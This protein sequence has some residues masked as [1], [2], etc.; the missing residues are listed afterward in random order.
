MPVYAYKALN[1]GGAPENGVIDADT[2]REARLKLKLRKLHVTDLAGAE[3]APKRALRLP[4]LRNRAKQELPVITRQLATL[5][6]SG[7]PLM[8]A[9]N[10]IIEQ[11]EERALKTILMDVRER[12]SQGAAFSDALAG[13]PRLFP[14]LYLNMVRSGEASGALDKILF[15]LADY[16]HAQRRMRA[17]IVAALSYPIVMMIVGVGVVSVLM[18]K[19]VPEITSVIQK[20]SKAALPLPTELLIATSDF[21]GRTWWIFLLA[22]IAAV[23]VIRRV[24]KTYKG[25]LW[26]DSKLLTVPVLGNLLRKS[27][28]SRFSLTFATLLESGLPVLGALEVVKKVVNNQLLADTLDDMQKKIAEGADIATPL[29]AS[30]VFPPVVGYMVAVG[31]ESGQLE[32]LLKRLASAYDEEVEIAAQRLTSLLEPLMIVS[33]A[34]VVGFIVLSVLLPILQMSRI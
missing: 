26:I 14:E 33:M 16:L 13:H 3:A 12:V 28:I 15:R 10:A 11:A 32:E 18:V 27:A 6:A 19:V 20:H 1:E 7:I 34:L 24:R 25:R 2:P 4:R 21:L 8:G 23:F 31:E 22:A 9:L 29:K 17:K 5:L 30:K